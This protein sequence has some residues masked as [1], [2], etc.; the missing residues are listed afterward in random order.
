MQVPPLKSALPRALSPPSLFC[1]ASSPPNLKRAL[2]KPHGALNRIFTL[3]YYQQ[4][5][6]P[7]TFLFS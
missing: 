4:D 3:F 7:F 1:P 2:N 5:E 6:T